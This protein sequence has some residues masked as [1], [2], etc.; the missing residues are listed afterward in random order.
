M[1]GTADEPM[2]TALLVRS[3]DTDKRH[4]LLQWITKNSAYVPPS[5]ADIRF[6]DRATSGEAPRGTSSSTTPNSPSKSMPCASS[7]AKSGVPCR[8]CG[9]A[10]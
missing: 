7:S 3:Y 1:Q 4:L 5:T 10:W 6:E 9:L 8:W 2:Q